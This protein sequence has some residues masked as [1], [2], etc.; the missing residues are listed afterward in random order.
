MFVSLFK[1]KYIL[2]PTN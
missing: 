1:S 2:R